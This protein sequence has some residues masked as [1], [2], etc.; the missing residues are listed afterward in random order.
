MLQVMMNSCDLGRSSC[1][2]SLVMAMEMYIS[3]ICGHDRTGSGSFFPF[4]NALLK[5]LITV[6]HLAGPE[7]IQLGPWRDEVEHGL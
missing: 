6:S 2:V 3:F 1:C 7:T 4:S 5:P